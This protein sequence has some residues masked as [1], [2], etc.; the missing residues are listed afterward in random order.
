MRSERLQE[1]D[2]DIDRAFRGN[3]TE[4]RMPRT[5]SP[6]FRGRVGEGAR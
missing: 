3:R 6:F 5:P 2:H 4:P 1:A